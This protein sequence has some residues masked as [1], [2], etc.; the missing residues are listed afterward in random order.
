MALALL[1]PGRLSKFAAILNPF[2]FCGV[3]LTVPLDALFSQALAMLLHF[4]E[5]FRV[6]FAEMFI[7]RFDASLAPA[8]D[9]LISLRVACLE[10]IQALLGAVPELHH[11]LPKGLRVTLLKLHQLPALLHVSRPTIRLYRAGRSIAIARS[12][13]RPH[14]G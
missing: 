14:I 1:I 9:P 10:S 8:H 4:G 5:G 13:L 12:L 7:T 2:E 6:F 11:L 3:V